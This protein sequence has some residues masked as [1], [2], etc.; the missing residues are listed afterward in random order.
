MAWSSPFPILS[1]VRAG[2]AVQLAGH[3][4]ARRRLR[5]VSGILREDAEELL[6]S[7]LPV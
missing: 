5:V 1:T 4:H 3:V 6:G 2:R 7:G